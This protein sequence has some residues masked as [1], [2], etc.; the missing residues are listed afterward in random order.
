MKMDPFKNYMM[1]KGPYWKKIVI[2]KLNLI[3][4]ILFLNKTYTVIRFVTSF[5]IHTNNLILM[6]IV[7]DRFGKVSHN[8]GSCI[9]F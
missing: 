2:Y 8:Y 3:L 9:N 1:K 4:K 7:I 5:Y 6:K